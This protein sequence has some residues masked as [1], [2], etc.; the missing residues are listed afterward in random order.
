MTTELFMGDASDFLANQGKLYVDIYHVNSEKNLQ[1]KAFL[2]S[3]QDTF[4]PSYDEE[5]FI[6]QPEPIRKWRSTVR[7]ISLGFNTIASSIEEAK[8]NLAKISLLTQMLYAEQ[9]ST[10]KG[11]VPKVGGSPIFKIKFA[12][13]IT[14]Q[15]E[16]G[17]HFAEAKVAGLSGYIT[18][19][20]YNMKLDEGFFGESGQGQVFPQTMEVS[21]TYHPVHEKSPAFIVTNRKKNANRSPHFSYRN[22]PY[23]DTYEGNIYDDEFLDKGPLEQ[24]SPF[25]N[26]AKAA[27]AARRKITK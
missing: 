23:G 19:F 3:F 9:E 5:Y 21:I 27:A 7:Q 20:N 17:E 1:F 14:S 22:F 18:D 15:K 8:T 25:G 24:K 13:L 16:I 6:M 2:T 11:L 12:N 10:S 26:N 4:S